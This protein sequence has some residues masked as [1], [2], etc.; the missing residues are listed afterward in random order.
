M[1]T[2]GG[3]SSW[4]NGKNERHI[5]STHNMVRTGLL[6]SNQH[7]NKWCCAAEISAEVHIFIIHSALYN[8]SHHFAWYG[9]NNSIHELRT[10][11]CDIYPI[12]SSP[13]NLYNIAQGEPFMGYIN[14]R[15]TMKCWDPHTKRLKYCS[16]EKLMNTII[17]LAKVGHQALKS[18]LAQ[19]LPPFQH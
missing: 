7:E 5:R 4:T 8:I 16:S 10:F 12:T 3:D 11:G 9:K 13:K 15:S 17:N 14:S 2:T 18:F 19:I 1:K 6:D